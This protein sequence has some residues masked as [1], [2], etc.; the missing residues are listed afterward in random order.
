MSCTKKNYFTKADSTGL[1]MNVLGAEYDT[2]LEMIEL[3]FPYPW[4]P[5][6]FGLGTGSG[7]V[8][9]FAIAS[10][11]RQNAYRTVLESL[12]RIFGQAN[13]ISPAPVSTGVTDY[14]QDGDGKDQIFANYLS[15]HLNN[16]NGTVDQG[17]LNA[18]NLL[19]YYLPP[20]MVASFWA[21][22]NANPDTNAPF[23][24]Q[25]RLIDLALQ[26]YKATDL[27]LW[28]PPGVYR[29]NNVPLY[30]VGPISLLDVINDP[31]V[32]AESGLS[33]FVAE[34]KSIE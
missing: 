10:A 11:D 6:G 3:Y 30:L 29:I 32:G 27:R 22:E 34:L 19:S 18:N 13:L 14:P 17:I 21:L 7:S 4:L 16:A 20:A 1:R 15:K 33:L 12:F 23:T 25:S 8:E 31:D 9:D 2:G 28:N 26:F 5:L 24:L